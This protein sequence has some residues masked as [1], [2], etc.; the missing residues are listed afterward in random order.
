MLRWYNELPV[1]ILLPIL[2]LVVFKP[3]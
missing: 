1:F 2:W 3:F